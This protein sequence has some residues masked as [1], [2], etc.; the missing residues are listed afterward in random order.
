LWALLLESGWGGPL[1]AEDH[2]TLWALEDWRGEAFRLIDRLAAD[3][4][5]LPWAALRERMAAEAWGTQALHLVD[6][7]DP[8]I[9]PSIDDLRVSIAQLRRSA[10]QQEIMRIL[11]RR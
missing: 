9:E 8:A 3:E 11:G 4:G 2:E 6:A 7:E 5:N 1:S 10:G